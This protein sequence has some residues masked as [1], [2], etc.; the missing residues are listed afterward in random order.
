M[1]EITRRRTGELLRKLFDILAGH[2]EGLAASRAMEQLA[3]AVQLTEYEK[4]DYESGGRRFDKIVRFATV[5][6]VKAGWLLKEKGRWTLTEPGR[7]AHS[8]LVDPEEFYRKATQLYRAWKAGRPD[9]E[10]D[11]PEESD[12]QASAKAVSVT[13]EEAEGQAWSEISTYVL[14]MPPYEF[15]ELVADLLRAMD[16]HVAWIAPP[17]KDGGVDIVAHRDPLGATSPRIKVQVKRQQSTVNTDG[18]RSF[19]AILSDGDLGLFVSAGGFTKDAAEEA[20]FQEKRKVTLLNLEQL[21][22]LWVEHYD[23]LSGSAKRRL[24]LRPIYFLEPTS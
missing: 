8:S 22:D 2:P 9:S 11:T 17:G 24:P 13:F 3:A 23:K 7:Q 20:R 21:F 16:Y 12:D 14:A 15:Q 6:C 18:V 5:D 10:P 4:G 19:M 1:P